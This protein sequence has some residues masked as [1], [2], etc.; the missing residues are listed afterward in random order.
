MQR[1]S[2]SPVIG[3][4]FEVQ[5]SGGMGGI[6]AGREVCKGVRAYYTRSTIG[7]PDNGSAPQ[8]LLP[9]SSRFKCKK[10]EFWSSSDKGACW[11]HGN[12]E[13]G[14]RWAGFEEMFQKVKMQAWFRYGQP[15]Y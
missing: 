13:H 2:T 9:I 5:A 7:L 11:A 6:Q 8:P 3:G 1:G 4:A 12:M 10:C 15:Q 14:L